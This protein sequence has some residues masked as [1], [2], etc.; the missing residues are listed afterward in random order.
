MT[1]EEY[2][3]SL[4]TVIKLCACAI[5]SRKPE[6]EIKSG[7][8]LDRIYEA[9]EKHMLT[10]AVGMALESAGIRNGRFEQAVARAQRKNA[11]MDADRI[12]VLDAMEAAGIWY[13]PLKGSIL[14]DMYPRYG[15]REMADVDILFDEDRAEDVK[16]IMTKMGFVTKK[17]GLGVHDVYYK[18]PVSNFEMHRQL[19]NPIPDERNERLN[20]YYTNVKTKLQ[21][22]EGNRFGYCFTAEDFYLY[23]ITHE[24][25]HYISKGT[26]L[27]SLLDVYVYLGK[28]QEEMD[29]SYIRQETEKMGI[30][31]FEQTNRSLAL[32]V[33]SGEKLTTAEQEMLDHILN[34][35]TYGSTASLIENQIRNKGRM[36]YFLMLIR[37]AKRDADRAYPV[38]K[39]LPVLSP[40][41][42]A[43]GLIRSFMVHPRRSMKE[44]MIMVK[45]RYKGN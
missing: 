23:L 34:A 31:G 5:K 45:G 7:E 33:F 6:S 2:R 40:L 8:N 25:K 13:M 37:N 35:G 30:S 4:D 9:A 3:E 14:K 11:L 28:K 1:A 18:D 19:I 10:A 43:W 44:L 27:R 22:E 39:K 17:Y 38:I 42:T 32:H 20:S 29:W 41:L 12:K 24:Y 16:A 15:M 26:G 21:K 36:K